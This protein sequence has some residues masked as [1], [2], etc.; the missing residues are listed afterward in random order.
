[1]SAD[2]LA[3][4]YFR[5]CRA[6]RKALTVLYDEQS[7]S[8]VI[9]ESQEICELL[10]KALLRIMG[11]EPPKFHDVGKI[12]RENRDL[13]AEAMQPEVDIVARSSFELRRDR[14][15]SFYGALDVDPWEDYTREDAD[16]AIA[17]IDH[18][19]RWA[20]P[21]NPEEDQDENP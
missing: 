19:M 1:M 3:R 7:Y 13:L 16:Q 18:I 4:T 10:L 6:R 20:E 11:I 5:K 17:R 2:Q 9:R 14:E 8:D 21:M 15:L 12:L